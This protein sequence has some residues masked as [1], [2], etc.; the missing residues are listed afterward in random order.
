LNKSHASNEEKALAIQHLCNQRGRSSHDQDASEPQLVEDTLVE[1]HP[2]IKEQDEQSS[3]GNIQKEDQPETDVIKE[4]NDK[5]TS[6]LVTEDQKETGFFLNE[7][8]N[9]PG[10]SWNEKK[11]EEIPSAP[12]LGVKEEQDSLVS[13][14]EKE[15]LEYL[16]PRRDQNDLSSSQE[17][18][19]PVQKQSITLMETF[20]P[21][22]VDL[23]GRTQRTEHPSFH[24]P[25]IVENTDLEVS[26]SAVSDIQSQTDTKQR[27]FKCEICGR[28]LKNKYIMKQHYI[29]H[30]EEKPFSCKTCGKGFSRVASLKDHIKTHTGEKPFPCKTCGKCFTQMTTLIGH[31]RTH[32]G[33]K[34]FTCK[35]CGKSFSQAS[36]LN[37]HIRTH[38]GEKPFICKTCGKGFATRGNL[39]VHFRNHPHK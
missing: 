23:R 26:S 20:T 9:E 36:T 21:Q 18:E 11:E 10:P 38:T 31:I 39:N 7:K 3:L 32:T 2:S 30:T 28:T 1:S 8:K 14:Y 5:P 22:E 19:Q 4:E 13:I 16:P 15:Q 6:K 25:P 24:R 34:P 12:L 17:E 33:E 29:T 37:V 35:T 27:P